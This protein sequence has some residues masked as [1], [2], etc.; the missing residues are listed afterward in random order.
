MIILV[1]LLACVASYYIYI[2]RKPILRQIQEKHK[3]IECNNESNHKEENKKKIELEELVEVDHTK[4]LNAMNGGIIM[5]QDE[6]NDNILNDVIET[7]KTPIKKVVQKPILKIAQQTIMRNNFE[8]NDVNHNIK[9]EE[10]ENSNDIDT[11]VNKFNDPTH[12]DVVNNEVEAKVENDNMDNLEDEY[13]GTSNI[14]NQDSMIII[15]NEFP[16]EEISNILNKSLKKNLSI[17]EDRIINFNNSEDQSKQRFNSM[18]SDEF[19]SIEE[20]VYSNKTLKLNTELIKEN[21]IERSNEETSISL[22]NTTIENASNSVSVS[23]HIESVDNNQDILNS[24]SSISSNK[25]NEDSEKIEKNKVINS[26]V[27]DN[28]EII[29]TNKDIDTNVSINNESNEKIN[30]SND[31]DSDEF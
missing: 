5:N 30:I 24:N 17:D 16:S 3:N 21:N 23:T 8:D 13:I 27:S 31:F 29:E 22:N 6:I 4:S 26:L 14:K 19:K 1:I 2:N 25:S 15:Q 12:T 20:D 11:N 7:V 18:D 10:V 9:I 28:I